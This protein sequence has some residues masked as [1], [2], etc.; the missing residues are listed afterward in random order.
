MTNRILTNNLFRIIWQIGQ[1]KTYVA[2]SY[3]A[4]KYLIEEISGY[5]SDSNDITSLYNMFIKISNSNGQVFEADVI[6]LRNLLVKI[7]NNQLID[8]VSVRGFY[9]LVF[10]ITQDGIF[11]YVGDTDAFYNYIDLF[12]NKG[13][14]DLYLVVNPTSFLF[15]DSTYRYDTVTVQSNTNWSVF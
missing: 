9:K 1:D 11:E 12:V 8:I 7:F 14:Q 3:L 15:L 13:D 4:F 10:K 6:I 5:I 2:S